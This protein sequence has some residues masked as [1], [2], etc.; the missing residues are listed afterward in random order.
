MSINLQ[1]LKEL[2][3]YSPES[4]E[5]TWKQSLVKNQVKVGSTAGSIDAYGY[6]VI[7]LL[8]RYY[9]AHRLAWYYVNSEWP[10]G[11]IDHING[12]RNDNRISNIR[13]V[14][15][16]TN[17]ENQ[18]KARVDS[19][20]GFL[21]VTHKRNKWV[22]QISMHGKRKYLGI[23]ESKEDAHKAYLAAKRTLHIGNTI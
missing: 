8:G 19:T 6:R 4:G 21:G 14:D 22:A 18:R 7:R 23:F 1:Q 3:E 5:F 10:K 12:I 17:Q 20:S 11:C 13:D 15:T 2:L 9:K 16:R